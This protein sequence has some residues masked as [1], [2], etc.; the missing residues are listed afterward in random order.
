MNYFLFF[1]L[2]FYYQ[3]AIVYKT[4]ELKEEVASRDNSQSHTKEIFVV[5]TTRK[6]LL[7]AFKIYNHYNLIP[8]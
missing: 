3:A 8:N 1:L 2:I 5:V 4:A 6:L 7:D